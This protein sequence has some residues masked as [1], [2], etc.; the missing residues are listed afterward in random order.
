MYIYLQHIYEWVLQY[1]IMPGTENMTSMDST[2][3]LLLIINKYFA[4][5]NT[6]KHW[7]TAW[8]FLHHTLMAMLLQALKMECF[9]YIE[10]IISNYMYL[11]SCIT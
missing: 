7:E 5:V 11:I 10:H 2:S 3:L 9:I 6:S 4:N 1:N 8:I